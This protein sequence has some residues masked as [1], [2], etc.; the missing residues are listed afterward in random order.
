MRKDYLSRGMPDLSYHGKEAWYESMEGYNHQMGILYAGCYTGGETCYVACNMH[1]VSHEL[2]LPTLPKGEKWH[3]A[4]DTGRE[5]E[6]FYKKGEEP[7][8]ENQKLAAVP[9]RTILILTGKKDE[10]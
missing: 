8:L 3:V 10:S 9:P 2:A 7:L 5:T 4:A 1:T 6:A